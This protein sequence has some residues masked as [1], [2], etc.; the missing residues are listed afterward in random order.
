MRESASGEAGVRSVN[1]PTFFFP[2]TVSGA[3]QAAE[4]ESLLRSTD[5]RQQLPC[6]KGA[7]RAGDEWPRSGGGVRSTPACPL[8][9]ER[10]TAAAGGGLAPSRLTWMC[11]VL[12]NS[13][14][15]A[16]LSQGPSEGL[17][18][19]VTARDGS[20]SGNLLSPNRCRLH[21]RRTCRS[22]G[23][24]LGVKEKPIPKPLRERT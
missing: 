22:G 19:Y 18:V 15:L 5:C 21:S 2:W 11:L 13:V 12:G 9:P 6:D 16:Y 4:A 10:E 1:V 20:D 8:T 24:T 17:A 23:T 14:H 7:P 3:S